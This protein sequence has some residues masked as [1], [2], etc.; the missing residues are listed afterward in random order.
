MGNK[1]EQIA[2]LKDIVS[3]LTKRLE[4]REMDTSVAEASRWE[5]PSNTVVTTVHGGYFYSRDSFD[6]I[7]ASL[8]AYYTEYNAEPMT[9]TFN[10]VGEQSRVMLFTKHITGV[11]DLTP[12]VEVVEQEE[13]TEGTS[14]EPTTMAEAEVIKAADIAAMAPMTTGEYLDA[15]GDGDALLSG[16]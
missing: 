7:K 11:L 16:N 2:T 6:D 5:P 14:V 1:D 8:L 3:D 13:V 12:H 10:T 9:L 15:V 4:Y